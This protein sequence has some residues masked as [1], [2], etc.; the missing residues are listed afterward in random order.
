MKKERMNVYLEPEL[1]KR[2]Y[3]TAAKVGMQPG[4]FASLAIR[5]GLDAVAI[6]IDPNWQEYF[7]KNMSAELK[8]AAIEMVK[9]GK[10]V[11]LSD[12]SVIGSE[13]L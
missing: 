10:P 13:E 2:I 3:D 6:A 12:G 11:T 5:A 8:Q 4:V 7:E 9:T 1:K